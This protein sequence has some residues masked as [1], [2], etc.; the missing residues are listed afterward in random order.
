[1][2]FL[3]KNKMKK[4]IALK[5]NL[6]T[7]IQKEMSRKWFCFFSLQFVSKILIFNNLMFC[8]KNRKNMNEDI[9]KLL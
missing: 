9:H 1:M 4:K 8:F 7:E 6:I 5:M 3:E 2:F